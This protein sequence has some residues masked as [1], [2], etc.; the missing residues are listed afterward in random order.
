VFVL[1]PSGEP[2][3]AIKTS[4]KAVGE[5][6]IYVTGRAAHAGL[7]PEDGINAVEELAAQIQRI[8]K[9][10]NPRRG[11]RVHATVFNG[12]TRSNVIAAEARAMIDLRAAYVSKI[13]PLEKRFRALKPAIPG[14]KLK[15]TGGF[16]R[17]PLERKMSAELYSRAK[18]LSAAMG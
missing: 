15:I 17:P 14:A 8:K 6:E 10:D 7:R 11:T 13:A 1:E 12:G 4:R 5:L 2:N 3:G 9:W 18:E 16:S